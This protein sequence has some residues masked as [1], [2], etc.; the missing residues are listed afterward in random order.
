MFRWLA[1]LLL[2]LVLVAAPSQA[3]AQRG[4]G[5]GNGNANPA[6]CNK[7]N[8]PPNNPHCQKIALSIESDIDFGTL[9]LIGNGVGSVW[10]D[11]S[12]G[13]RIIS[14]GLDEAG[15][16]PIAGRAIV[17]GRPLRAIRVEFPD[18]ITM[19]DVSGGEATLRD[20]ATNLPAVPILDSTGTLAFDFTGTLL[21]DAAV[22]AGGRLRGRVPVT[23][24]YD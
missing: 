3:F 18:S 24:S 2:C 17:T 11:L 6:A 23:V 13:E 16:L 9:V 22:A 20:F 8:P 21:T 1:P 12:T 4:N 19:T 10:I 15:G 5:N 14:G 7:P